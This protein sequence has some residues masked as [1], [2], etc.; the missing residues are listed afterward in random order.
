M[1]IKTI[2]ECWKENKEKDTGVLSL[3]THKAKPNIWTP[4]FPY[5]IKFGSQFYKI[6]Y[7][8]M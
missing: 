4:L 8:K 1:K 3:S 6:M 7:I 5:V 2:P